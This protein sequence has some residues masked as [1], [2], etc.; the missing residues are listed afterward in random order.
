M[1]RPEA[2]L[3]TQDP[4]GEEMGGNAIR[5][6][7]LAR[8]LGRRL[9]VVLAAPRGPGTLPDDLEHVPFDPA[10]PTSLRRLIEAA[11]VV[12]T[13]PQGAEVTGWLRRSRA[14][15]IADLYDPG[16]LEALEHRRSA[17]AARRRLWT[18]LA[19]DQVLD[20]LH[21]GTHFVC[22]TERQRDLWIGVM[23]GAR[24][25]SPA[26]YDR[27][28]TLRSLIDVVPFGVPDRPPAAQPGI[29][30]R[31]RFGLGHDAEVILWNG[32]IW[33][34]LDPVTAVRAVELLGGRR[35][36]VRLVFMGRPPF[37]EDDARAA[38]RAR[39][40]AAQRGLL[41][42]VVFFN[43]RWVPYAERGGWLLDADCAIST[44]ADHVE[45]RFAF[46]TRLLDCLWAGLPVV[47]TDGDELAARVARED[48]GAVTPPG[49]AE[50]VAAALERVLERGRG[51]YG[52]AI[53]NAAAELTWPRVA[54]PLVD[55]AT[56]PDHPP[57]LGASWDRR[58]ARP[59]QRLRAGAVRTARRAS[60]ALPRP[61]GRPG[62]A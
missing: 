26:V 62:D 8:A 58:A 48:L 1:S 3:I 30:A 13:A 53:A 27:D 25:L 21:V 20:A 50:A 22:A 2:L 11:R 34:W 61:G 10:R 44:H 17:T 57:R 41:E 12:V 14:V 46:R 29:G 33:N 24:L 55:L 42:R 31:A 16:P 43:D 7:E 39:D 28:P 19:L 59:V 9:D 35:P 4:V 36:A 6:C 60:R 54:A 49:D 23:L 51:R 37:A 40:V 32:G 52:I 5:A 56:R 45:T 47:C 15:V 38:R 18:T